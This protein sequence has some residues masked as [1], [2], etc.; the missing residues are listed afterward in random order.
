MFVENAL[1]DI[2]PTKMSTLVVFVPSKNVVSEM[3]LQIPVKTNKLDAD[4]E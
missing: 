4:S 3:F 1:M 2:M